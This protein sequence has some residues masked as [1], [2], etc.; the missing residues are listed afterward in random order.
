MPSDRGSDEGRKPKLG[1]AWLH[2]TC[3]GNV[4]GIHGRLFSYES[5]VFLT[6]GK[7]NFSICWK[8]SLSRLNVRSRVSQRLWWRQ[9]AQFAASEGKPW[10]QKQQ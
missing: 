8:I 9:S 10:K 2:D 5:H 4:G 3:C 1:K 6:C 7:P